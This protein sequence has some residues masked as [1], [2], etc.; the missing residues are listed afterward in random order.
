[1][2]GFSKIFEIFE[3]VLKAD[4]DMDS[5]PW[6][7]I[8]KNAKKWVKSM[9]SVHPKDRPTA[10]AVLSTFLTSSFSVWMINLLKLRICYHIMTFIM[11]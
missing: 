10:A 8:S 2:Y 4:P 7:L 9:L 1:M 5:Y 11:Q 3:A 6:P